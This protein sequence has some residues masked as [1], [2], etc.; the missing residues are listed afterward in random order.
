MTY[1]AQLWRNESDSWNDSDVWL[2]SFTLQKP[3]DARRLAELVSARTGLSTAEVL[4]AM[5]AAKD[6]PESALLIELAEDLAAEEI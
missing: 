3:M 2:N 4:R 5:A 1:F 6:A